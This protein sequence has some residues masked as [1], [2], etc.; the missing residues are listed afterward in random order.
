[1]CPHHGRVQTAEDS[2]TEGVGMRTGAGTAK[3][4]TP[5]GGGTDGQGGRAPAERDPA[6][7]VRDADRSGADGM[8]MPLMD[9]IDMLGGGAGPPR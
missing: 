8:V 4:A 6:G 7:S 9:P 1:M 3:A 2:A 5:A